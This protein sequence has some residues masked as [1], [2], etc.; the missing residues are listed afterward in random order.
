M[1]QIKRELVWEMVDEDVVC[2]SPSTV[3]RIL[4]EEDLVEVEL[5]KLLEEKRLKI[6]RCPHF[7]D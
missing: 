1:F 3:Y 4:S 2:L 5:E 7:L 6:M